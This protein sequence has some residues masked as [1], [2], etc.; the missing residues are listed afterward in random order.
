MVW[1]AGAQKQSARTE[2]VDRALCAIYRLEYPAALRLFRELQQND[3]ACVFAPLGLLVTK[4]Y[5]N[6]QARGHR[7]ANQILAQEIEPVLTDYRQ[8]SQAEPQDGELLYFYGVT[9]GVKGR[10]Q[11]ARKDWLGILLTGYKAI[12]YVK[13]ADR[14]D[15]NNYDILLAKGV[16]NYYVGI[17]AGYMQLA[18][19]MLNMSG[20]KELGLQQIEAAAEQ[21]RY[22]KYEAMGL[23][24]FIYLYIEEQYRAALEYC[25]ALHQLF[26]ENPYYTFLLADAHLISGNTRQ[27]AYWVRTLKDSL[28]GLRGFTKF[29]YEMKLAYLEGSLALKQGNLKRA[30]DKLE[31]FIAQHD[32]E[33]DF[34]LAYAYLRAGM[35]RD[36]RG[37]R[38]KALVYYRQA[39]E[40]D[41]RTSAC[42]KA[43]KYL[44]HPYIQPDY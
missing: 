3:S 42:E 6:Q 38:Q 17:S 28:P 37:D 32:L 4:W 24:A 26:P 36:L 15:P 19:W 12:S 31:Y 10:M 29:E 1:A 13:K 18:S 27:A 23:L 25:Q 43:K 2:K 44:E 41:N 11:L 7:R 20:S 5:A 8:R 30:C 16:F 14:L 21:A 40:L 22:G 34:T 39:V 33:L 9:L 35:L